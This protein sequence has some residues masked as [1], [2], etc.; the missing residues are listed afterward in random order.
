[1]PRMLSL[2]SPESGGKMMGTKKSH[3]QT[4]IWEKTYSMGGR[5]VEGRSGGLETLLS[6]SNT[7]RSL[8]GQ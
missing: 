6:T 2:D 5:A 7:V 3:C 8:A 4:I 1:M